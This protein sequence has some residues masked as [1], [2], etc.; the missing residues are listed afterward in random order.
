[1]TANIKETGAKGGIKQVGEDID[2]VKG[3]ASGLATS[4]AG[5]A[6]TFLG[7]FSNATGIFGDLAEQISAVS[8]EAEETGGKL[9][10][11]GTA[12]AGAGVTIVAGLAV[13][14]IVGAFQEIG[15]AQAEVKGVTDDLTQSLVDNGGAWDDNAQ[16]ALIASLS[17][18]DAFKKLSAAG[19]DYDT[20]MDGLTGK[21]GGMEKLNQAIINSGDFGALKTLKEANALSHVGANSR[22]AA[23]A[24]LAYAKKND[25][26]TDA[27]K[28]GLASADKQADGLDDLGTAASDAGDKI[29]DTTSQVKTY[30]GTEI[31][32]KDAVITG[33]ASDANQAIREVQDARLPPKVQTLRGDDTDATRKIAALKGEK[34]PP[35]EAKINVTDNS[36]H[37]QGRIQQVADHG[38]EAKIKVTP[39]FG[40][41]E[42]HFT[43]IVDGAPRS[44]GTSPAPAPT[45]RGVGASATT[46]AG[47]AVVNITVN[48]AIDKDGTARTIGR[49]LGGRARRL[50]PT[51]IGGRT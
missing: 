37:A 22:K 21:Q 30:N 12:A 38:Y 6:S 50:H 28:A 42:G 40:H 46:S 31:P 44:A 41:A 10:G 32:P 45:L 17:Q 26:L 25:L 20:I 2:T 14:A 43:V 34:F 4:G 33:D 49:L 11:L 13:D 5:F 51:R 35:L 24:A 3:K 29:G 27:Q 36:A 16:R 48:G 7:P 15:A 19:I 47:P 23:Q 9:K 39:V 1:V 8:G 18:T